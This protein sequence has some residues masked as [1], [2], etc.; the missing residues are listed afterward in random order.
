[1]LYP[2][3]IGEVYKYPNQSQRFTLTETNGFIYRFA[4]GHWC[5]DTVF[6]DLIRVKTGVQVYKDL[7]LKLEI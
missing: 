7:Q 4:C 3:Y 2:H 5:T 6:A 1:M